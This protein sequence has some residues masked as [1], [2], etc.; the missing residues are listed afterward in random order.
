MLQEALNK[1]EGLDFQK[2]I[3]FAY[4]TCERLFPNYVYFSNNYGFG[5]S[6]ALREAIDFL[7]ENIFVVNT[8][9]NKIKHLKNEIER[10][11]PDT[12]D[13]TTIFV[14]PALDTCGAIYEALNFLIDKEFTTIKSISTF[15]TDTVD[16]Y[17]QA[18]ENIESP[19]INSKQKIEE[20]PL[21]KK[22][23]LIQKGIITFLS[24]TALI[25]YNDIQTLLHLQENNKKSNLNL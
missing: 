6:Q 23:V 7:Y 22:E 13:F 9:K 25:D 20:H 5:N 15:A 11:T 21:I 14:S 24:N 10:N 8:D 18:T 16:M 3:V 17:V 19:D 2:Q 12:E 1:L 4:L